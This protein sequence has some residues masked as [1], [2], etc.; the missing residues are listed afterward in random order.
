MK[1]SL[2]KG[3]SYYEFG[4]RLGCVWLAIA[5]YN[6]KKVCN[7]GMPQPTVTASQA[8]IEKAKIALKRKGWR[9]EDL[10]ANVKIG[11][12]IGI[13]IQTVKKFFAN[14]KGVN[15][16]YF[17]G[18][19]TA[20]ELH[21]P[22]IEKLDEPQNIDNNNPFIPQHGKI[23]DRRFFFG[24][25][26]EIRR[27]FETLNSGSSV[28][29]VGERAIG[30]SSLLQAISREAPNQ[31]RYARQPIYLDLKNVF[32]EN[33]FYGALCHE[34]SIETVKG[35]LLQRALESRR[36]LLLLD[37]VEKMTW[38]EFTNQVR[39]QLRGLAEGTNA[40]L[41]L[42]VAA[43]TSLDTLFP[44]SQDK[45]M[46]SPFKGICIEE[47][48]KRWDDEICRK[49]NLLKMLGAIALSR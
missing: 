27:V 31:L 43:C 4:M 35:F 37:E 5:R 19:C 26:R 42:V 8:G 48:L 6:T 20:L 47:T 13:S 28:A 3:F 14:K 45:N 21:W 11:T 7:L 30:K 10:A 16:E 46:T 18:I 41:R 32:D 34:A 39:G 9:I 24:R 36:F 44:D 15:S 49:L 38:D 2:H 25:E 29:V 12:N 23:D 22:D 33:D 17:I 40:P 1:V